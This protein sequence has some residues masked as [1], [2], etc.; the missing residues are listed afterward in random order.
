VPEPC[1]RGWEADGSYRDREECRG[2]EDESELGVLCDD[3]H[4]AGHGHRH[5]DADCV[6]VDRGENRLRAVAHLEGELAQEVF[7][8]E[9]RPLRDVLASL[10][11]FQVLEVDTRAKCSPRT[12]DDHRTDFRVTL[13][14][15]ECMGDLVAHLGRV[16][17]QFFRAIHR[18]RGDAFAHVEE[19]VLVVHGVL[20]L[21]SS[22]AARNRGG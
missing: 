7:F 22:R 19:D 1:P 20:P 13:H 9:S 21:V 2:E 10:V 18:D 3:P 12:G 14:V 4:I 11:R 15:A 17:I 16:G 5:S 8:A 6:P